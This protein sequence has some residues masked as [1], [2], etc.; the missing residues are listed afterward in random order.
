M[1][2]RSKPIAQL[3]EEAEKD[4]LIR[5]DRT[6]T[7]SANTPKIFNKYHKELR[8]VSTELINCEAAMRKLWWEKSQ[9]Y[10]GKAH[11]DVYKENPLGHKI[12]KNDVK[13][14]VEADDDVLKLRVTLELLEMKRKYI[15]KKMQEINNRSH[16]IRNIIKTQYFKH[17][18]NG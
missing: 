1:K 12:M 18:M 10:A 4:L 7:D 9:Y 6:D 11:P 3:E 5:E 14:Y 13:L 2:I 15:E 8:L 17:G 16:H